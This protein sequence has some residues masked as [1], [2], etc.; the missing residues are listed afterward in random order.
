MAQPTLV[1]AV[2]PVVKPRLAV[3]SCPAPAG[4]PELP[5]VSQIFHHIIAGRELRC[6][7]FF[8]MSSRRHTNCL[9]A[10]VH[11]QDDWL[12]IGLGSGG[13]PDRKWRSPHY[14]GGTGLEQEPYLTVVLCGHQRLTKMILHI[15][16]GV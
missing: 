4:E 10:G 8:F 11:T 7:Y 9:A 12:D 6:E 16:H 3:A 15:Y 5:A 13:Q 14:N 1:L 2:D